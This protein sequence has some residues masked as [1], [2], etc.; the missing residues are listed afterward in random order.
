MEVGPFLA[1]G[2]MAGVM[3]AISYTA[4]S[5]Y[6]RERR[7]VVIDTPS[8]SPI[9]TPLQTPI[10]PPT[11]AGNP[12]A[13]ASPSRDADRD[14]RAAFV[15][16]RLEPLFEPQTPTPTQVTPN[17][18]SDYS[19]DNAAD[20][21]DGS[22]SDVAARARAFIDFT[23]DIEPMSP[24]DPAVVVADKLGHM[25]ISNGSNGQGSDEEIELFPVAKKKTTAPTYGS[26]SDS[27]EEI[28]LFTAPKRKTVTPPT[29]P[30]TL[31][32]GR[33]STS[34]TPATHPMTTRSRSTTNTGE[35]SLVVNLPKKTVSDDDDDDDE[36][37]C[38]AVGG[39]LTE[40]EDHQ[41][42]QQQ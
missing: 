26:E 40:I 6:R 11:A 30:M 21:D 36:S 2:C 9:T 41:Q 42:Q 37:L 19:D 14:R 20:T 10:A 13:R 31:R 24:D 39:V 27:D 8:Q 33:K 38:G 25:D 32:K 4:I 34:S 15:Q 17:D 22:H 7:P 28:E 29:H 18:P 12:P 3:W 23:A 35:T 5:N 16:R 1:I